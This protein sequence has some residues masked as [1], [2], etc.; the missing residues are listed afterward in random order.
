MLMSYIRR[1]FTITN[2]LV[3]LLFSY[4][5][6]AAWYAE[7]I[8]RDK[9]YYEQALKEQSPHAVINEVVIFKFDELPASVQAAL[10]KENLYQPDVV[11]VSAT[12]CT[13]I[14]TVL[15]LYFTPIFPDGSIGDEGILFHI[16]FD[17]NLKCLNV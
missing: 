13:K 14:G 2:I 7:A 15:V 11:G 6:F 16:G 1:F 4:L 10:I 17:E 8:P 3:V 9:G 5:L 12:F